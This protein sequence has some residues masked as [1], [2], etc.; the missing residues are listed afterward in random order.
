MNEQIKADKVLDYVYAVLKQQRLRQ[1]EP[2]SSL[3]DSLEEIADEE[4]SED[5]EVEKD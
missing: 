3:L 4:D 5:D 2:I 1:T